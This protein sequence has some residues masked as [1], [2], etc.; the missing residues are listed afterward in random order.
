MYVCMYIRNN[1]TEFNPTFFDLHLFLQMK[2]LLHT[3]IR[4]S[5]YIYTRMVL[6]LIT[7]SILYYSAGKQF[8]CFGASSIIDQS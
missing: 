3:Y 4:K 5:S 1:N 2:I 8:G 6:D 7:T